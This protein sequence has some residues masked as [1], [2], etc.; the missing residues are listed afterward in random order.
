[1]SSYFSGLGT[2]EI[3][4]G[5]VARAYG[6]F[7]GRPLQLSVPVRCEKGPALRRLLCS[8]DG[9]VFRN[10]FD[11]LQGIEPAGFRG[12]TFDVWRQQ[13]LGA[14][15]LDGAF[16]DKHNGFCHVLRADVDISGSP[17][18][19]WS[20]A[21]RLTRGK[22]HPDI[23][24]LLAWCAL[25]RH[26]QPTLAVHENVRGF[27]A[28]VLQECLGDLYHIERVDVD[29]D[30]VGFGFV[31]RPRIYFILALRGRVS[32]ADFVPL[33]S[34]VKRSLQRDVSSW[35]DWL[36]RAEAHELLAEENFRRAGRGLEALLGAPSDDWAYLLTQ[37]QRKYLA[38]Y[39]RLWRNK[40]KSDAH[41]HPGVVFDLA[42]RPQW[43]G[44]RRMDALP[45]LRRLR[46]VLWSPY[47][48]RW[49]IPQELSA[50]MGWPVYQDLAAASGA[51]LH[52]VTQT[53]ATALGNTMHTA[54][55]GVVLAV[56]LA[57]AQWS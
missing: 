47:R 36:A 50:I 45:S 33:W 35:P 52:D 51:P 3:A 23:P 38:G 28:G 41:M 54:C 30:M 19:P 18:R 9:C 16:C 46:C 43:Q 48:R 34:Q 1:M 22:N 17:C 24:A 29:P 20:S 7:G 39:C 5:M 55:V 8:G 32:L 25:M 10:V 31:R 27:D 13:I 44:L 12:G 6:V 11:R 14:A 56:L 49:L 15:V 4:A 21:N 37:E 53:H 40:H 2:V 57:S 26:D 42:Q